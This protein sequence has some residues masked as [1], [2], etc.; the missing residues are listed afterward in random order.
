MN[1]YRTLTTNSGLARLQSLKGLS[2][3]DVRYSRVTT[4][5][6]AALRAA[7]P[8]AKV[9][10]DGAALPKTSV[11][12]AKPASSSPQAI[13]AWIKAMGGKAEMTDGGIVAIDLGSSPLSD[14]QLAYL[15][16][17]HDLERLELQITQV[18]DL[19]LVSVEKLTGLKELNLDNTTVSSSGTLAARRITPLTD[20]APGGHA[21]RRTAAWQN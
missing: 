7:L 1:L 18:S 3:I 6:V 13:V 8:Q 9:R 4:N 2:D 21:S 11:A 16:G 10:F 20:T 12:S 17:L 14:A 19:G 5:G 15:E